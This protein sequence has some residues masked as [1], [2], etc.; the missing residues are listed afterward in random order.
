MF[1]LFGDGHKTV[2]GIYAN[3]EEEDFL[4]QALCDYNEAVGPCQK[5]LPPST[6]KVTALKLR[7]YV[8]A[9]YNVPSSDGP[10]F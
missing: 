3:E 6:T 9:H 4:A 10:S 7:R 1:C 2:K 5:P 8:D